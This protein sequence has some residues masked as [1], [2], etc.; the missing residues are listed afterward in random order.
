MK[1]K[2]SSNLYGRWFIEPE[3]RRIAK[4]EKDILEEYLKENG[5]DAL[6]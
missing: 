2:R 4:K 6:N 1:I 5:E 3:S